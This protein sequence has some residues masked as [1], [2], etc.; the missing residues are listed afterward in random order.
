MAWIIFLRPVSSL[1]LFPRCGLARLPLGQSTCNSRGGDI[2][3]PF[4]L[5]ETAWVIRNWRANHE[6]N[7]LTNQGT[8]PDAISKNHLG[9][10]MRFLQGYGGNYIWWEPGADIRWYGRW[11][12]SPEKDDEVRLAGP[13][14]SYAYAPG[15]NQDSLIVSELFRS[16]FSGLTQLRRFFSRSEKGRCGAGPIH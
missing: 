1:L 15:Y 11:I 5:F 2:P 6:F 12:G 8:M 7:P 13:P 16:A 4:A 3:D 9:Y 14:P 10:M